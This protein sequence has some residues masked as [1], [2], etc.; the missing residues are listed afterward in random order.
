MDIRR[1]ITT[2]AVI[3]WSVL[4][5]GCGA[6]LH[7]LVRTENR[8]LLNKLTAGMT[9]DEIIELMGQ[10]TYRERGHSPE[11][12]TDPYRVESYTAGQSSFEIIF[13]YTDIKRPDGAIT[14]DELTPLVLKDGKL[15]G[16]GWSYW[17]SA[18]I[19]YNIRVRR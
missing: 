18:A 7:E 16:W 13:Y 3:S 5:L 11:I 9:K 15:A 1:N 6:G 14:D 17:E 4:I 19:Q 12:V 2:A 10:G 8:V